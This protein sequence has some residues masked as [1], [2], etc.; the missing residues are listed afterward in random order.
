LVSTEPGQDQVDVDRSSIGSVFTGR[1][2]SFARK[3]FHTNSPRGMTAL[4]VRT[5]PTAVFVFLSFA[6][7]SA[8]QGRV[9]LLAV[10]D[11][12]VQVPF[13]RTATP[14]PARTAALPKLIP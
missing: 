4:L 10:S 9:W 11:D 5:I 13:A 7:S 8:V 6:A 3:M 1:T 2:S 12:F 14:S